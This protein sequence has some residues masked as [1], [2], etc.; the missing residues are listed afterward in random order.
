MDS[1]FNSLKDEKNRSVEPWTIASLGY[2]NHYTRD[3]S[4]VDY[5][6]PALDILEEVQRTG[7]I[8][9]PVNWLKALLSG[10]HS[11]EAA[12]VKE[13]LL[14]QNREYPPMLRNKILQQSDHLSKNRR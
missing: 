4:S 13:A 2:L 10:H 12:S 5:I 6:R 14:E 3:E 9:F 1:V 8:F 11:T 7:D